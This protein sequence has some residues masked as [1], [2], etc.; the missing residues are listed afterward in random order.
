MTVT[1]I[2]EAK[3]KFSALIEE[4]TKGREVVIGRAGKPVALL[5]PFTEGGKE[6]TPG[7]LEG[8]ICIKDDFDLL[9]E[10]I[11]AAFGMEP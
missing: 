2:S 10:D 1:S 11:A 8:Q 7:T 5:I 9:P 6:R 3:A 4:V